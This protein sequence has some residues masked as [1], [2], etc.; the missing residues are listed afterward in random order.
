M[1]FFGALYTVFGVQGR[2]K[3]AA[4]QSSLAA[5]PEIASQEDLSDPG[6]VFQLFCGLF[7]ALLNSNDVVAG[8]SIR[9]HPSLPASTLR[10]DENP[11]S[12]QR[13]FCAGAWNN[14]P[15]TEVWV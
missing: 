4:G 2:G 14:V 13:F 11:V 10:V 5:A 3:E 6:L 9:S 15:T 1:Q 12:P 8:T 7:D